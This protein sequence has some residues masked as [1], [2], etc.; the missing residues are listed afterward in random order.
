MKYDESPRRGMGTQHQLAIYSQCMHMRIVWSHNWWYILSMVATKIIKGYDNNKSRFIQ[1]SSQLL[2]K[3]E[4]GNSSIVTLWKTWNIWTY[5]S[6][7]K[8][9]ILLTQKVKNWCFVNMRNNVAS[10]DTRILYWDMRLWLEYI[11]SYIWPH[12][13]KYRVIYSH[14]IDVRLMACCC[15]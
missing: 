10:Y 11:L 7:T 9:K 6:N 4:T 2:A 12:F 15:C 3:L 13:Y 8:L 14:Y 5:S 1:K